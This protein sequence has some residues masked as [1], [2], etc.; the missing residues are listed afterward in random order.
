[1][2]DPATWA[3]FCRTQ[4]ALAADPKAR[5]VLLELAAEYEALD[6]RECPSATHDVLQHQIADSVQAVEQKR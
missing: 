5:E 6:G 3:S 1:M 2:N 4:A